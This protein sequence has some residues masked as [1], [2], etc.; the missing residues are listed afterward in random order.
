MKSICKSA[1]VPLITSMAITGHKS[2]SSFRIYSRPS[3]KQ[4]EALSFL[5]GTAG[6]LPLNKNKESASTSRLSSSQESA[7]TLLQE[8]ESLQD[9]ESYQDSES[10]QELEELESF[11]KSASFSESASFQKTSSFQ[12][13]TSFQKMASLSISDDIRTPLKSTTRP[14][15]LLHSNAF[16]KNPTLGGVRRLK[17]NKTPTIINNYY[18]IT[19]D[20]VTFN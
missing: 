4:K 14:N 1:G 5:I 7:S 16:I 9:S 11:Q 13:A 10:F 17:K 6:N 3:D 15:L 18:N 2:E 19:A 12:K 8:S 20:S